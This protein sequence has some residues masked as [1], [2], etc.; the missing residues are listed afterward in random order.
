MASSN[1]ET[2]LSRS[3]SVFVPA[4]A[5]YTSVAAQHKEGYA[6]YLLSMPA[7]N[8]CVEHKKWYLRFK[9]TTKELLY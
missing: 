2:E 4:S 5:Q 8:C 7:P 6:P 9:P 3:T 1:F